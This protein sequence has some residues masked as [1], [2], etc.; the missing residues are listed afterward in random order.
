MARDPK[1]FLKRSVLCKIV[2]R[3]KM[4]HP[5]VNFRHHQDLAP[6]SIGSESLQ[7]ILL[8]LSR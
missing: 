2:I 3:N 5:L 6:L 7:G 8:G 1:F 4:I